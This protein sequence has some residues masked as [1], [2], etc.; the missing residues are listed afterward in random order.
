M[1]T[2]A[3]A[4]AIA[5]LA[6]VFGV[7]S[8]GEKLD[9]VVNG[10]MASLVKTGQSG[11]AE[12]QGF[13]DL[14]AAFKAVSQVLTPVIPSLGARAVVGLAARS[15]SRQ[16]RLRAAAAIPEDAVW[17][18]RALGYSPLQIEDQYQRQWLDPSIPRGFAKGNRDESYARLN[19]ERQQLLTQY[20]ELPLRVSLL[21]RLQLALGGGR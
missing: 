2:P 19:A 14:D 12:G 7:T 11:D 8:I 9:A 13:I 3:V 15:Q 1:A 16:A 20:P 10:V 6:Q 5:L 4:G 21:G 17:Q 18:Y